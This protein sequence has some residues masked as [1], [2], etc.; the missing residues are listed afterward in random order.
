MYI[1]TGR[2]A[3]L[4]NKPGVSLPTI[5]VEPAV[6]CP[7]WSSGYAAL[8]AQVFSIPDAQFWRSAS[9]KVV[10]LQKTHNGQSLNAASSTLDQPEML[11]G[12]T[13]FSIAGNVLY[14]LDGKPALDIYKRYL[15]E[16]AK[17]LPGSGLLFHWQL[18]FSIW[19]LQTSRSTLN[20]V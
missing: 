2:A 12:R 17:D 15:G 13:E 3:I 18:N 7:S 16:Y 11:C 20:S 1:H 9:E 14:E 6:T 4:N 5:A 8:L 19:S 10:W